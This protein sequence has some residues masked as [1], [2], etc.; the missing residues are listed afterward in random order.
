MVIEVNV[1]NENLDLEWLALISEA[2][3]LGIEKEE[4]RKF[5]N[6][7]SINETNLVK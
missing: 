3:Q 5:L 1:S 4:V 2:K 6:D 7:C